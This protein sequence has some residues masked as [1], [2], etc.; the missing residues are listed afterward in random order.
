MTD[1]KYHA[2]SGASGAIPALSPR[3]H[4]WSLNGSGSL[5][6]AWGDFR[7][8]SKSYLNEYTGLCSLGYLMRFC[9]ALAA[10]SAEFRTMWLAP[11]SQGGTKG[12]ADDVGHFN[13]IEGIC[14][15]KEPTNFARRNWVDTRMYSHRKVRRQG[16]RIRI[17]AQRQ[18]PPSFTYLSR[19]PR[20]T[21]DSRG[22]GLG[23]TLT[24]LGWRVRIGVTAPG[25]TVPNRKTVMRAC[26]Y[27]PKP[28]AYSSSI[29]KSSGRH[30]DGAVD[31]YHAV[32][33]LNA[34]TRQDAGPN[35]RR[36]RAEG[37]MSN[38]SAGEAGAQLEP[39]QSLHHWIGLLLQPNNAEEDSGYKSILV[40]IVLLIRWSRFAQLFQTSR[41]IW[42]QFFE[43]SLNSERMVFK[44][45]NWAVN[46]VEKRLQQKKPKETAWECE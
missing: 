16:G 35:P 25:A 38:H 1:D 5:H 40:A 29:H 28:A 34:F 20:V 12:N 4:R 9:F 39:T 13:N 2:M 31:E 18:M 10:K 6:T 32:K 36:S 41:C 8:E 43:L 7:A 22:T 19:P 37:L 42:C 17:P 14:C 33:E 45:T 24:F 30:R 3:R 27:D 26:E 46:T 44:G 23:V 11:K 21:V 15:I